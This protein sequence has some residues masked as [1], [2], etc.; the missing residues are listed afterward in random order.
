MLEH[1]IEENIDYQMQGETI[2][3][4]CDDAS[5]VDLALSFQVTSHCFE[6]WEQIKEAQSKTSTDLLSNEEPGVQSEDIDYSEGGALPPPELGSLKEI[7]G[8][9][10]QATPLSRDVIANSLLNEGYFRKLFDLFAAAEDLEQTEDVYV[11]FNIFK[12]VFLLNDVAVFEAIL[13]EENIMSL[14]AILEYDPGLPEGSDKHKHRKFLNTVTF[15]EVVPINDDE[16]TAKIHQNYKITYIKDAILLRY[17]DDATMNTL[18]SM[19][20]FNN[21]HIITRLT[22]KV[23]FM[24]EFFAKLH[25]EAGFVS[26]TK[27]ESYAKRKPKDA[28]A[29]SEREVKRKDLFLFLQELCTIA[30][31]LQVQ[32]KDEFYRKLCDYG[33]CRAIEDALVVSDLKTHSWLWLACADILTNLM[34][35]DSAAQLLRYYLIT[36]ISVPNSLLGC[37]VTAIVSDKMYTG[38]ADQ[39]AQILRMCLDPDMMIQSDKDVFLDHFYARHVGKLV[40]CVSRQVRKGRDYLSADS[41]QYQAV[42]LLSFCVHNH[43]FRIRTHLQTHNVMAKVVALLKLKGHPNVVCSVVRFIRTCIGLKD[44]MVTRLLVS[45][46]TLD[47]IMEVFVANGA[48]YNL[49]NSSVIELVDFVRM[50]NVKSIV[51]YLVNSRFEK[52]FRDIDYVPTFQELKIRDQ[53]NLEYSKGSG[54]GDAKT[55]MS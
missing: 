47:P 29:D 14:I 39:L 42:E 51:S 54:A 8:R 44:D 33:L 45:K 23:D 43:G 21:V 41:P 28:P 13:M 25:A 52:V 15:K 11:M 38:L 17:L 24:K 50:E 26:N 32:I 27:Q 2:V 3:T 9:I 48:R 55:T 46:K 37:L 20:F 12:G 18:N 40:N 35:H 49:L 30:K 34:T 53:Q 1:R 31:T 16:V 19:I 10:N 36:R 6:V 5:S 22:E 7:S 4:W